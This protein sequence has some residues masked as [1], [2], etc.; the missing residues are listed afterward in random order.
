MSRSVELLRELIAIPSVNP[1]GGP[2]APEE[3]FEHRLSDWLTQFAA[4]LDVPFERNP[5]AQLQQQPS[6]DN[7]LF[8]FDAGHPSCTLLWDAHQDTVPSEGMTIPPFQAEVRNGRMYGRGAADVK[9]GM[10]AMIAAFERL[11][12]ERPPGCCNVVLSFTCDEEYS[13][14]GVRDLATYWSSHSRRSTI[15]TAPPSAAI[16]AEPT[17]LNVVVAHRGVI[18]FQIETRGRAC[19]SSQPERGRNAIYAMAKVLDHLES[20]AVLLQRSSVVHPLCGRPTLSVGTI[21]GGTAVNIVPDR[22]EIQVDRRLIPGESAEEVW[23]QLQERV[24]RMDP[25]AICH[26]PWLSCEALDNTRNAGLAAQLLR[27]TEMYVGPKQ[28][29]CVPFGTNASTISKAGVP[30]VVFGP[31][32]IAQA[33]TCD[34]FI[35]LDQ[36]DAASQILYDVA[37]SWGRNAT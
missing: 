7:V 15:L 4:T 13:A 1:M 21:Q 18:R 20:E 16:V 17:E 35:D 34:E 8:Y 29:M 23:T 6:R 14:K 37:C 11:V 32:S 10:A 24:S 12:R 27:T 9:G 26:R 33:H 36:L 31:G 22:C 5:I 30:S 25:T 28:L 3:C 2:I 19:H